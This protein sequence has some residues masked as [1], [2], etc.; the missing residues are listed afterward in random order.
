MICVQFQCI[1][2]DN[3]HTKEI[4]LLESDGMGYEQK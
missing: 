4:I 1:G 3:I 2:A